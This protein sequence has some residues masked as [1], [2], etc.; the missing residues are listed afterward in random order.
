[1]NLKYMKVSLFEITYKKK[2]TFSRHS[3]SLRCTCISAAM[4]LNLTGLLFWRVAVNTF[5][6]L[7]VYDMTLVLLKWNGEML[8][9]WLSEQFW[10]FCSCVYVLIA[11]FT[12]H[13]FSP[14]FHSPTGFDKSPTNARDRRE[15]GARSRAWQSRSVNYRDLRESPTPAKYLAC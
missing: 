8:M 2:W 6:F 3:N 14:I 12:L 13:D 10:R 9:K 4:S 5:T 15:I 7:C 11:K 1:M